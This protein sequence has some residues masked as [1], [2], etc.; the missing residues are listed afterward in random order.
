MTTDVA[1]AGTTTDTLAQSP[2]DVDPT[3]TK[4]LRKRYAQKLRGRFAAINTE[5]RAGVRD[6]DIFGL[7][8]DTDVLA[9]SPPSFR[10]ERDSAK[11][12]GFRDWLD[13]QLEN[14]VLQPIGPDRNQFITPAYRRGIQHADTAM[15]KAGIAVQGAPVE[16]VTTAPL[17]RDALEVAYTRNFQAL[18]G[19]NAEVG[20]QVSRELADGLTEGANP[21]EMARRITDRVDKIGKTRATTMAR[22]EVINAHSE[23]TLNRFEENDVDEVSVKAEFLTAGDTR[24]CPQ[25]EALEGN[26]YT[27]DE[28]RGLIPVHP[29]CRCTWLPKTN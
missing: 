14:E 25:C 23:A 26:V 10:F 1:A 7:D 21:N 28:A 9:E 11:V 3:R 12:E 5:I 15:R 24:V 18:E 17:H 20:K 8:R 4:T 16:A 19:I 2:A 27:V 29:R 13:T 22:T 6:R